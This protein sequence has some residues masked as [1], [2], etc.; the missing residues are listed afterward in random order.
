MRTGAQN[1][2]I[3]NMSLI[4]T[5]RR[6]FL[7]S[8]SA[9]L[10]AAAS[11]GF[12]APPVTRPRA[13]AGDDVE[14]AWDE[15]L[16]VTVGHSRADIVGSDNRAI[17]AA[18]DYVA[19]LGGGVVRI[20]PGAYRFRNAVHL[21]SGVRIK[22]SGL[23][24][25]LVKEA[26]AKTDLVANSDWYEREITLA[27]PA[28]FEVGDGIVL[29]G[30]NP[31]NKGDEV[32]KATL[33][34]RSGNRFKLDRM[35]DENFWLEGNSSAATLFALFDGF[36]ISDVSIEDVWLD[37]NR[38]NN[39]FL[40]GNHIGC[41]FLRESKGV[42]L[43]R[44]VARNFNGDGI[45][46]QVAH[47]VRV[48]NCESVNN[49]GLG[50]HPGSGSQRAVMVGNKVVGNDIGIFFCWGVR[51]SLAEK[52][53]VSDT[54]RHGISLGHSDTD[55][56]VRGNRVA[57]SGEIGIRLRQ[58]HGPAFTP[59]RNRLEANE[60]LDSGGEAGIGIDIEGRTAAIALVRNVI[61][62]SRGPAKRI[63]VRIGAEAR[64]ISREGNRIEGVS[65]PVLDLR[66]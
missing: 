39:E 15:R 5:G 8:A 55:N 36:Q 53:T 26:S 30:R 19:G 46:W 3:R 33:I 65:V 16:T 27:N 57:R 61:T 14:P 7:G 50:L 4:K 62:E 60:V 56:V 23:D 32:R 24:S 28:G 35:I 22:G 21:R 13:T 10:I 29:R 12:Q 49:A 66:G 45:S 18:V 47:D 41:I 1:E 34:A 17:Q 52:N 40:N 54:R 63:G 51:W 2:T 25:I 38:A 42:T 37:G 31:H 6:A 43:R 20:L 48:V 9:G 44:V 64:D 58:E 11:D 59:D